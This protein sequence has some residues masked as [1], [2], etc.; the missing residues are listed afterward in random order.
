MAPEQSETLSGALTFMAPDRVSLC[1]LSQQVKWNSLGHKIW[2]SALSTGIE[3]QQVENARV[4]TAWTADDPFNF[5]DGVMT[6]MDMEKAYSTHTE[7][8]NTL[9]TQTVVSPTRN[10]IPA[11]RPTDFKEK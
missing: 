1:Y 9:N 11:Y 10:I 2:Y 4:M 5:T 3:R 8:I 6:H 7:V